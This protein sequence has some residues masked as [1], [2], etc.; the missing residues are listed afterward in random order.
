MISVVPFQPSDPN[1]RFQTVLNE[2]T[3]TFDVR[4]NTRDEAWYFDL[5]DQDGQPIV[6]GV[7]IV[8]GVFLSRQSAHKFF[9]EGVLAAV[10]LT[11]EN[12]DPGFDDLGVRVLVQYYSAATLATEALMAAVTTTTTTTS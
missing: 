7:K 2:D 4:W 8:L 3:Y 9:T 5:L 11:L 10:D 1:Y 12:R 6:L